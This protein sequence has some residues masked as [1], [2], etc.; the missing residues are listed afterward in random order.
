MPASLTDI[1]I[2]KIRDKGPISFRDFMEMALYYPEF[3]YYTSSSEK[4]GKHGDYYTSPYFSG[5]FGEMLA[6]QFTDM[7][8]MLGKQP[9][10]IVEYGAGPGTLC[11]DVLQQLKNQPE[12][13]D[14]L[15]YYIIEKSPVMQ[16]KEREILPEKIKW[17]NSIS[18]LNNINGCIFSNECVDNFAVHRVVMEDELMEIFVDYKNGFIEILKPASIELKKYL[19]ELNVVLPEGFRT[20]INLEATEWI[21][22]IANALQK[23]FVLTIDYGYPAYEYYHP[24]RKRGTLTCY[25]KHKTNEEPYSF[26]GEQDITAHVNFTALSH[27]GKKHGLDTYSFTNQSNFLLSLGL[28]NYLRELE[29]GGSEFTES[30]KGLLINTFLMD[31]GKKFQVLMQG[32]GIARPFLP[33][34]RFS[35][36][37]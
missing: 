17:I 34:F 1:I 32:K 14:Q 5:I 7:W 6:K 33:G 11:R 29:Q 2:Q 8:H 36:P 19:E 22:D 35:K 25:N 23:G 28:T 15:D 12:L 20:E 21:A 27:F 37:L 9:F 3:G 26:I 24:Q 31:M 18:N 10:T 13:Y 30:E 16:E 4:I